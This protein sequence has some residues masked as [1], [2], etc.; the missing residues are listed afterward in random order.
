[1]RQKLKNKGIGEH[2]IAD[3]ISWL[4]SKNLLDDTMFAQKKAESIFRTKL[5]GPSYIRV[6]LKAA[7]ISDD[8]IQETLNCLASDDQW[9]ARAEQA[10]KQWKKVHP[11]QADDKI[12]H[13]RFLQSRGFGLHHP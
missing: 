2:E 3:V 4:Q 1:M 7:G 12:R 10:I 11:K 8:I 6:K 13:M 9:H 5:V